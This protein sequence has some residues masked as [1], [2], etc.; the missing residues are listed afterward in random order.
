MLQAI[1]KLLWLS[2]LLTQ[3][4]IVHGKQIPFLYQPR[5]RN[6]TLNDADAIVDIFTAAFDPMPDWQYLFPF[7]HDYPRDHKRCYRSTVMLYL[8][9]P[10][11]HTEVIESSSGSGRRLVAAAVWVQNSSEAHSDAL[12]RPSKTHPSKADQPLTF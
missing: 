8:T 3:H 10:A 12:R 5:L 7:R 6:A 11:A 1:L 9:H 2:F 4:H